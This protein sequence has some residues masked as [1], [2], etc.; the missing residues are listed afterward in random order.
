[1]ELIDIARKHLHLLQNEQDRLTKEL[2]ELPKVEGVTA[3]IDPSSSAST[4]SATSASEAKPAVIVEEAK[5]VEPPVDPHK[6]KRQDLEVKLKELVVLCEEIKKTI[7]AATWP[8]R[9]VHVFTMGGVKGNFE[10][11]MADGKLTTAA[12]AARIKPTIEHYEKHSVG[13]KLS[14]HLFGRPL[15]RGND[16]S[17]YTIDLDAFIVEANDDFVKMVLMEDCGFNSK[18][19]KEVLSADPKALAL[20]AKIARRSRRR[21]PEPGRPLT[22]A[23]R[24]MV[25]EALGA[26]PRETPPNPVPFDP[27]IHRDDEE[28]ED[29][30]EHDEEDMEDTEED[31]QEEENDTLGQ[32]VDVPGEVIENFATPQVGA[33][34]P[35][36]MGAIGP[37]GTHVGVPGVQGQTT[38]VPFTVNWTTT[39]G[40]V[41]GQ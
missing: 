1:M 22:V 25:V 27:H 29:D 24:R 3:A 34:N 4:S 14:D 17:F 6:E 26:D 28:E 30:E 18:Q 2:N 41:W 23:Q 7:K 8:K 39:T 10:A 11:A 21:P 13:G 19:L 32:I 33:A 16:G 20:A 40:A 37:I 38:V 12:I 31:D 35:D 36:P 5:P 9:I 15:F